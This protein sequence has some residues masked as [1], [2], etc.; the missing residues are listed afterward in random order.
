MTETLVE[1]DDDVPGGVSAPYRLADDPKS[2]VIAN[3]LIEQMVRTNRIGRPVEL[4]ARELDVDGV[5]YYVLTA[6]EVPNS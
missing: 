3:E 2:R 5:R 1:V 4:D 6:D